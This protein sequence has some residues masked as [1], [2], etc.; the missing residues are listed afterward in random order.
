MTLTRIRLELGR[1]EGFPEGS[2]V[3]GY[4]FVAPLT[5]DGHIDATHWPEQKDKCWVRRFWGLDPEERGFLKRH[6]QH[7]WYFDYRKRQNEDDEPFFK[8]DRHQM[9][10][11]A[12]V[13]I[14]EHDGVQRPFKIVE[15][16]PVAD[17]A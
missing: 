16:R 6:G 13:S 15:T 2:A 1:M 12:Y 17:N 8:L 7:G 10:K 14:T 3:H 11:D 9:V 5:A 4:E